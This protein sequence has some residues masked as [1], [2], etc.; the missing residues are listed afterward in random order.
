MPGN[1]ALCRQAVHKA[2][3]RCSVQQGML[4]AH[5]CSMCSVLR[6]THSTHLDTCQCQPAVVL[7]GP[8]QSCARHAVCPTPNPT[9]Q[10]STPHAHAPPHHQMTSTPETLALLPTCARPR[11]LVL[12][13]RLLRLVVLALLALAQVA[14]AHA[15][16]EA[17]AVLLQA[18][19]LA[20][21]A[22]LLVLRLAGLAATHSHLHQQTCRERQQEGTRTSCGPRC[23]PPGP[24][25]LQ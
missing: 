6:S 10:A 23:W 7:S 17:L 15:H 25:A 12:P 14:A 8:A 16:L 22:P 13:V 18:V 24:D 1:A 2:T 9:R 19:A 20:A 11:L 4:H 3:S 21:V 5:A